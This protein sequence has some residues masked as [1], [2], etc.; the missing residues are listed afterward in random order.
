MRICSRTK[1]EGKGKRAGEEKGGG[2]KGGRERG[3]RKKWGK[4]GEKIQKP[5]FIKK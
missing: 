1:G 2:K 3:R 4:N 5:I